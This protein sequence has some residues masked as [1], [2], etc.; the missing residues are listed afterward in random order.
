MKMIKVEDKTW[1]EL[2]H[3]K[4]NMMAQSLDEVIVELLRCKHKK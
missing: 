3:L 4:A 2:T 1:Q